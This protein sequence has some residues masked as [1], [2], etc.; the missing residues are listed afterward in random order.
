MV[1]AWFF[2]VLTLT[3]KF[4]KFINSVSGQ[5]KAEKTEIY[6]NKIWYYQERSYSPQNRIILVIHFLIKCSDIAYDISA[7]EHVCVCVCV[8]ESKCVDD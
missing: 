4:T 8:C 5:N 6:S 2:S 7:R 3:H 1:I